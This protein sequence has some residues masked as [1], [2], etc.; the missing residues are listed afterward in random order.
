MIVSCHV[1]KPASDHI[2]DLYMQSK[3]DVQSMPTQTHPLDFIDQTPASC[4]FDFY[5]GLLHFTPLWTAPNPL[6]FARRAGNL[7]NL[8]IF[9]Q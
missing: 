5:Y 4:T 9:L 1:F 7:Y 8:F 3:E 6:C 2:H